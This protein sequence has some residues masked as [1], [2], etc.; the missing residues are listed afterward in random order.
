MNILHKIKKK[1]MTI[2]MIMMIT[3]E[4][5]MK[6]AMKM[7]M[8]MPMRM[9]M[10]MTNG[11]AYTKNATQKLNNLTMQCMQNWNCIRHTISTSLRKM[12]TLRSSIWLTKKNTFHILIDRLCCRQFPRPC[13]IKKRT[14]SLT[15]IQLWTSSP[16]ISNRL[17]RMKINLHRKM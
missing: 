14:I 17:W 8:I 12:L 15:T 10:K 5:V 16:E 11:I 3:M 13:F 9:V 7:V 4:M 2:N 1:E 6:I